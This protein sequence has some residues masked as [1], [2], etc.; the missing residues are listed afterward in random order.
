VFDNTFK[1]FFGATC[2]CSS[3]FI[4]KNLIFSQSITAWTIQRRKNILSIIVFFGEYAST[5]VHQSVYSIFIVRA[6]SEEYN[7]C[8][9]FSVILCRV[10]EPVPFRLKFF[11]AGFKFGIR[12]G[13]LYLWTARCRI[14]GVRGA[15]S[16][17]ILNAHTQLRLAFKVRGLAHKKNWRP[18]RQSSHTGW[19]QLTAALNGLYYWSNVSWSTSTN[20]HP[21]RS[22]VLPA[23]GYF[24]EA[25]L[26]LLKFTGIKGPI[27]KI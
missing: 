4:Q 26:K 1:P 9:L 13:A 7:A 21:A 16:I 8:S 14:L 17:G 3:S 6:A 19:F 5:R 2:E 23:G 20:W 12:Q 15:N 24:Y 27:R 25:K 22:K 10:D 11:I 18:D